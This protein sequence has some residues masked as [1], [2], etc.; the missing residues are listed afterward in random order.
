MVLRMA[1][2]EGPFPLL[3]QMSVFPDTWPQGDVPYL[4]GG[5]FTRFIADTY[6]R[7]KLANLSLTY[8]GRGFPFLVNSTADR[9]LGAYYGKLYRGW[10]DE[11][12]VNYFRQ[13]EAVKAKGMTACNAYAQRVS[14]ARS[15][16]LHPTARIAYLVANGDEFGHLCRERRRH[17]RPQTDGE[18]VPSSATGST[19]AWSAD[20]SRL[21]YTKIEVR[22]A[23]FYDDLYYYDLK[24]D[25]EVRL[26]K[27]LRARDPQPSPDGKKLL[28]VMNRMGMTRLASLDLASGRKGLA[29]QKDVVF[30]TAES[31]L[32]YEAPFQAR[33]FEDRGQPGSQAVTRTS[34]SLTDTE[35]RSTR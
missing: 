13:H 21:Y 27:K 34:G 25:R 23:N 5:S 10:R 28:F 6:G 20:G 17:G 1:T 16:A 35:R 33:R 22:G 18:P 12:R 14:N 11:L 26:T 8:S 32:Q 29:E 2:L 30:L 31:E 19:L 7:E 9:A 15:F 24:K 3:S 4:F